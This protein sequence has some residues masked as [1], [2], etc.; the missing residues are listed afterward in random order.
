MADIITQD[1]IDMLFS[2]LVKSN[3]PIY[4]YAKDDHT[5]KMEVMTITLEYFENEL[6]LDLEDGVDEMQLANHISDKENK[7]VQFFE[8]NLVSLTKTLRKK[9]EKF[10]QMK[11]EMEFIDTWIKSHPEY[12]V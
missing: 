4:A 5:E 7:T 1:E 3:F 12:I 8:N 11:N 6:G 10:K 2:Y 9:Q